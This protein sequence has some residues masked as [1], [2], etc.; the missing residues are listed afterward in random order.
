MARR[1]KEMIVRDLESYLTG[2]TNAVMVDISMLNAEDSLD[3]RNTLRKEGIS[4]N[5]VKNSLARKVLSAQGYDFPETAFSGPTAILTSTGD[6]ITTTKLVAEWRKKK[7]RKNSI[8]IKGGLLEGDILGPEEAEKLID[9]PSVQ[10]IHQMLVSAIAG[11]L[12]QLVGITD[13][14]LA[15]VPRALQAIADKKKEEGE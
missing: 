9:M 10:Q 1:L 6:A 8:K 13:S 5:V 14:I 12:T 4:V 15:N 3:Y 7:K 2:V 11:P